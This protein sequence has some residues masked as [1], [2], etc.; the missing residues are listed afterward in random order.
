[1]ADLDPDFFVRIWI[2]TKR[3]RIQNTDPDPT[4]EN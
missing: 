4:F 3:T 1:M 2:Q